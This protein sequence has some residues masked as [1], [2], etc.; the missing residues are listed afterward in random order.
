MRWP[1]LFILLAAPALA[2]GPAEPGYGPEEIFRET[3][4]KGRMDPAGI[5]DASGGNTLEVKDGHVLIP[6]RPGNGIE[7][8]E[9][10]VA[11]YAVK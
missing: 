4:M 5:L 10:A 11:R 9:D 8:D 3:F 6:D 2:A 7:W 1:I